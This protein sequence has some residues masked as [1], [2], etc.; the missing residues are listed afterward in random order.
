MDRTI[1]IDPVTRIEGHA[2]ITI[3]LDD[4]GEVR[5]A[6]FHITQFRG[7]ER[8]TQGRPFTEMPAI[9]ARICGICPIS[10]LVASAKACDAIMAVQIPRAAERLR[11]VANLAQLIQS[12]A[13]SFFYLSSPDFLLGMDGDPANRNLF[14]VA[15]LDPELARDGIRL[16][17]LGQQVIEWLA[18]RRI[19]PSWIVPGGVSRP[20]D[21]EVRDRI[22]AAVP[23][24]I[25]IAERR[26]AWFGGLTERFAGEI[27]AFANFPSLFAALVGPDDGA[28]Y[29]DGTLRFV[30]PD[31]ATLADLGDP[32]RYPDLI[33]EA[34]EP[35]TYLKFPYYAPL[36]YPAGSYRVGPLARLNVA[37]RLG[38]PRADEWLGR[39][40]ARW[41]GT[42]HGSFHYHEARLIE[43]LHAFEAIGDLLADPDSADP[44]VRADAEVNRS[45]GI[46]V[47]EAPRGTLIHHY[48]VDD[49][50]L[51]TWVNLIIATGQNNRAMNEGVLQA[52]RRFLRGPELSEGM[53]NRV[54][55]VI[56]TFDPCL[57]CSTHALGQMPLHI[58]LRGPAGELLDEVRR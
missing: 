3:Q 23:E 51:V 5:D 34:V 27:A 42:V 41:P 19:H 30:G 38:T 28:E 4:Q 50:G 35:W 16:R 43:I 55:A 36:G 14:G 2:K 22:L 21:P 17:Q 48:R 57:S 13:L 26:L 37:T 25:T 49:R 56:R 6:A 11:R 39:F 8:I 29:Y 40:R 53:L 52:A 33:G 47:A 58:Q 12:H 9:M 18:G 31:G 20:L 15:R 32:E 24:G 44:R 54:E 45:E 46:G 7:F 10:H 1:T